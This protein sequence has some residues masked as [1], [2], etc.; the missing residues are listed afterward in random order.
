MKREANIPY[1]KLAYQRATESLAGK[2]ATWFL[3]F[4]LTVGVL[5]PIL[6]TGQPWF[7]A[8]KGEWWMPAFTSLW[9]AERSETVVDPQTGIK[10]TIQF[11]IQNWRE[12]DA[13][14]VW[15]APVPWSPNQPDPYN[16]DFIS[17]GAQQVGKLPDGRIVPLN[18][19]HRHHLGTDQLGHDVLSRILNGA[20]TSMQIGLISTLIAVVLGLFFGALSGYFGNNRLKLSR[21]AVWLGVPGLF[22]GYFWAFHVRGFVLTDALKEG[23]LST[24]FQVIWSLILMFSVLGIFLFLGQ[25]I[26][27]KGWIKGSM[28]V[29]LDSLVQRF[30]EV[31]MSMPRLMI[32]LTLAAVFREKSVA[33]V[34]TIIG[35]THWTSVSRFA[36]AEM[37]KVRD[38]D[39]VVAARTLGFPWYRVLLKHALPGVMQPVLIETSFLIAGSIL[40]ESSLSFLGIGVPENIVSW[41]ALLKTGRLQLDAWWLVVYPGLMIFLTLV[42]LNTLGEVLQKSGKRL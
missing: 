11:D 4:V 17:P 41:G 1:W 19:F 34:I 32:I 38:L 28:A 31:F 12:L 29:P 33:M 35:L 42:S 27:R 36:R 16:R 5:A 8:Y 22:T 39:Y 24:T 9:N 10:E 15:W 26:G 6:A 30:S 2:L 3:L 20:S 14:F 7:I 23:F 37:L 18:G 13:E 21:A 25:W 40:V